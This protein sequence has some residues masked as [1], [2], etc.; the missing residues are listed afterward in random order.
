MPIKKSIT[1]GYLVCLDDGKHFS[2]PKRYLAVLGSILPLGTQVTVTPPAP[3]PS[4]T[5][6]KTIRLYN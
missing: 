4:K 2:S 3:A 6:G 5:T 1:D